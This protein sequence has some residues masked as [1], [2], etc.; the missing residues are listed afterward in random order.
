MDIQIDKAI[1][2]ILDK[3]A[4]M[5]VFSENFMDLSDDSTYKFI[6]NN[7]KKMY[8][9][10]T[11]RSGRFKQDSYV[12]SQIVNIHETLMESSKSIAEFLY[13]FV[14]NQDSIPG[15]DLLFA[16][17]K[18]NDSNYLAIVK[19]NYKEGYTHS[20]DYSGEQVTNKIMLHRVMLSAESASNNEG[21]LVNLDNKSLR[22]LE[23]SYLIDGDRKNYFSEIF[24]QCGTEIS[25]KESIKVMNDV[26][27][28]ITKKYFD[29]DFKKI[30]EVKKSIYEDIEE[31][32]SLKLENVARKAFGDIEEVQKEYIEEVKK[33]G[34][35]PRIEFSGE[36]PEK[37]YNKYKIKTDSGIELSL[38]M[39]I[40]KEK[41]AVEFINNPDGTVSILIRNVGKIISK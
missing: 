3:N 19:L 26:A 10:T 15:G 33:A 32:G 8:D 12:L 29:E 20:V 31:S 5:P 36:E 6:M 30:A 24:L 34:V 17:A 22:I 40:Y 18:V 7:I 38:P 9:D 1:L 13:R 23:K 14:N 35:R 4:A 21:V 41:E 39:E 27:K 16:L 11:T 37:K 25:K 28:E 2:H